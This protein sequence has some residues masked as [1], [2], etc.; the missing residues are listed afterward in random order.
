MSREISVITPTKTAN[1]P[2]PVE[3]NELI[4]AI[5]NLAGPVSLI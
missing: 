1:S 5:A 4:T 2:K 3:P